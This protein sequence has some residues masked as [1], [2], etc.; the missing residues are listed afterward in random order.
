MNTKTFQI[1]MRFF[2][3][4]LKLNTNLW[5]ILGGGTQYKNKQKLSKLEAEML[6]KQTGQNYVKY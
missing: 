1:N 4:I 6:N 3:Q 5:K 2:T